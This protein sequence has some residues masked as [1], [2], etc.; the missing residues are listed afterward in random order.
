MKSKVESLSGQDY[1]DSIGDEKTSFAGRF[2]NLEKRIEERTRDLTQAQDATLNILEDLQE[3]NEALE[4]SR[5]SFRNVVGRNVDGIIV[6]DREGIV[7]FMNPSTVSLFGRKAEE[8]KGKLF[9]FP[10]VA[11]EMTEIDIIR[12]RGDLGTGEMRA[13]ETEWEGQSA[14]LIS[15]RDVTERNQAVEAL[16]ESEARYQEIASNIPGFVYQ[17][18][19]KKDGTISFPFVS[20]GASRI[21][22]LSPEEIMADPA[23]FFSKI[24]LKDSGMINQMLDESARAM[25]T[26]TME[27]RIEE[28]G[29]IKWLRSSADPHS[30]ADGRI[31][32]NGVVLDVTK[33][34]E[35]DRMKSEFISIVGHEL[36]TPLT[37]IKNAVDIIVAEKAG[38]INENQKRFL[39]MAD[40]NIVRL[41]GII[42]DVLDIS[43]IESG[44]LRIELKPLQLGALLDMAIVP[45]TSRAKEKAISIHKEIPSDLPRA[46]GDSDKIEQIF[47]NL[48]ENSI[49]FTPKGGQV[50]VSA[51]LVRGQEDE[52]SG[53]FIEVSVADTGIGINS[54]ELEK[55]FDPFYQVEESLTRGIKGT[56]LGLSIVKGLVEAHG[57]KLWAESEKGK[58]SKFTFTV[59]IYNPER[60]LKDYLDRKIE[61]AKAKDAP[62]SLMIVK[63]EEFDY[64]SKAY[65]E[66]KAH[67][68]LHEVK[69]LVQNAIRR[70]TDILQNPTTGRV[71]MI[72]A[73]TPKEGAYALDN[74]LKE[75]LSKQTLKVNKSVKINLSSAV[76]TYPEDGFTADELMKKAQ[77]LKIDD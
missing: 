38:A 29:V 30:L 33:E 4:T 72:L 64:L 35:T 19:R 58:G 49:K 18:L 66:R 27:F 9:G 51:K 40:R 15:I 2:E 52:L 48:F 47:I 68:L 70:T 21:I 31:L 75:V 69:Q 14:Y 61:R 53:D 24:I 26:W 60:N 76:A 45:L 59:P 73:D 8:F 56:G 71:I 65:G 13:V 16:R 32:W 1:T 50:Y 10:I 5:A 36:R 67:K 44:R 62:L 39:S 57:G 17:L 34:K 43:K 42:N 25:K 46:Y 6:T 23:K 20:E 7:R 55:V 77:G 54:D 12:S 11:G 37:S 63:I 3:T 41:S 22:N 74:R 28:Q